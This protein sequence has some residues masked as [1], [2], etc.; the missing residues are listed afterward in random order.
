[1]CLTLCAA[2]ADRS[3]GP[4]G[5]AVIAKDAISSS[6]VVQMLP[7]ARLIDS[8]GLNV[9]LGY[10]DTAYANLAAVE[11][12]V[13]DL[14]VKH[15]RDAIFPGNTAVTAAVQSLA[16]QGVR[17][18]MLLGSV[19]SGQLTPDLAALNGPLKGTADAVES[20][21]EYDCSGTASW[22]QP[23]QAYDAQVYAAVRQQASLNGVPV[24]GPSFCRVGD[25]ESLGSL[26]G[27]ADAVNLHP[28]PGGQAP[29]WAI[30]SVVALAKANAGLSNAVATE[31]GYVS[32]NAANGQPGVAEA[33]AADYLPRMILDAAANG[34]SRTYLYELL[35]EKPDA[36]FV[37]A[38]QH[39]GLVDQSG[40]PKPA[41][42]ALKNLLADVS[43]PTSATAAVPTSMSLGVSGG[44]A[45]LRKVV[46]SD[47]VG[48]GYT[49]ALWLAD[50]RE[51]PSAQ[52]VEPDD[53]ALV[54]LQLG[55]TKV[56]VARQPS[57]S[58][59]TA[60]LGTGTAFDIPVSGAVTL[61]H[62]TAPAA[63]DLAAMRSPSGS[64]IPPGQTYQSVQ[65]ADGAIATQG[66]LTP[67]LW[68]T[69]GQTVTA[70]YGIGP[71]VQITADAM[72]A[73]LGL[74]QAPATW[75]LEAWVEIDADSASG[76]SFLAASGLRGGN[77]RTYDL[78]DAPVAHKQ[79]SAYGLTTSSQG[80][81]TEMWGSALPGSWHYIALVNDG[82]TVRL[83]VDGLQTGT[84]AGASTPLPGIDLGSLGTGF[85]GGL[86]GLG[87]YARALS[88]TQIL[89]HA[90]AANGN[91]P[92]PK[93]MASV[94]KKESATMGRPRVRVVS[95]VLH[96]RTAA[97][98]AESAKLVWAAPGAPRAY[99]VS[100]RVRR[101]SA[102]LGKRLFPKRW[103]NTR[104]TGGSLVVHRG[105]QICVS[106]RAHYA[107]A[108]P[109]RWSGEICS[110]RG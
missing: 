91:C 107:H 21:N 102:T 9:H 82:A 38:E 100:Y 73:H 29:E 3:S 76:V 79:I 30:E 22:V 46:V 2:G 94:A 12:F 58:N 103:Q 7:A 89:A 36:G 106:A 60:Y 27:S 64:S 83:Y 40:Q 61:V 62:I 69:A 42:A 57:R 85:R 10:G 105:Y 4:A 49:I 101:G 59:A 47:K 63:S 108:V 25:D 87:V 92:C 52:I 19:G 13:Q 23:L 6:T 56:A 15:L 104:A 5:A 35:D 96:S 84:A 18:D 8:V 71:G 67:M 95:I 28:Y 99:D 65:A 41:Y 72:H 109:T 97:D 55:S 110:P 39:F 74:P 26:V 20:P 80:W 33:V 77:I 32:P 53:N 88:P 31:D 90:T 37:D 70:P 93:V 50:S 43:L 66:S 54:R 51:D 17:F 78:S 98:G 81:G 45:L 75:T 14:G 68:T 48:G 24:Y 44:G 34:I 11:G 86:A 1:M 16:A